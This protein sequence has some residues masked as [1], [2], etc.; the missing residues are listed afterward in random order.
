MAG[1]MIGLVFGVSGGLA[2]ALAWCWLLGGT[3]RRLGA[4]AKRDEGP[5]GLLYVA[6][7]ASIAAY[8]GSM[9]TYDAFAF[10]QEVFILF[11]LLA[12]RPDEFAQVT[13]AAVA[14][15]DDALPMSPSPAAGNHGPSVNSGD[16]VL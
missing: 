16:L 11:L 15:A 1:F 3:I 13:D 2:G 8:A 10:T 12:I 14:R 4:A 6:L 7:A 9:A 5:R